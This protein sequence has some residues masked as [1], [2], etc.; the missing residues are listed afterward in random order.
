MILMSD[1][2]PLT[3][4]VIKT[5]MSSFF[6]T[7]IWLQTSRLLVQ[8]IR[9]VFSAYESEPESLSCWLRMLM[10]ECTLNLLSS[11]LLRLMGS[12]HEDDDKN[13]GFEQGCHC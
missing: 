6:S 4:N 13:G 2:A 1:F 8:S 11:R 10:E 5:I 3:V 9:E 7:F 12:T